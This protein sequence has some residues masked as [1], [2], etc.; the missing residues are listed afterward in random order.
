MSDMITFQ[1][2][3]KTAM[4][5]ID[6]SKRIRSGDVIRRGEIPD[7]AFEY[8]STLPSFGGDH[9]AFVAARIARRNPTLETVEVKTKPKSEEPGSLFDSREEEI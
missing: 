2:T 5:R 3:S 6:G 1:P 4:I 7:D 8:F 9:G